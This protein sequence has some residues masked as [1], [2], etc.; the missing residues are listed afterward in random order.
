M[1]FAHTLLPAGNEKRVI[2]TDKIT[3]FSGTSLQNL[4]WYDEHTLDWLVWQMWLL[5]LSPNRQLCSRFAITHC[6]PHKLEGLMRVVGVE[7]STQWK[8]VPNRI[9]SF[10]K[11]KKN[12]ERSK[13]SKNCNKRGSTR[14]K[15][16]GIFF[17]KILKWSIDRFWQKIRL[18]LG[19]N[20]WN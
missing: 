11:K 2:Q 5:H 18:A 20:I 4:S 1:C 7:S 17:Y 19:Q 14:L 15:T 16:K 9:W 10:V 8:N 6:T 13:R 12:I 3:K